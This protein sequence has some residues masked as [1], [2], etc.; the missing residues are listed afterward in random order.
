MQLMEQAR[1]EGRPELW[2]RSEALFLQAIERSPQAAELHEGLGRLYIDQALHVTAGGIAQK[3]SDKALKHF[4]E[5]VRLRPDHKTHHLSLAR[6][7]Q[8]RDE[9]A[10]ALATLD[11]ALQR[12]PGDRFV[13]GQRSLNLVKLGRLDEAQELALQLER[14]ARA[15][16][17]AHNLVDALRT[18]QDVATARGDKEE[19]A[20]IALELEKIQPEVLNSGDPAS[21]S[22]V[23]MALGAMY[24]KLG[25]P[26]KSQ[27]NFIQ[28]AETE[29][30]NPQL[31]HDV[32]RASLELG[33]LRVARVF[34]DRA[35]T[36]TQDPVFDKTRARIDAALASQ[37]PSACSAPY[38]DEPARSADEQ[39]LMAM[40]CFDSHRFETARARLAHLADG[41]LQGRHH[42][43]EGYIR[44]L[45]KDYEGAQA[46]F[47]HPLARQQEAT[48]AEIGLA[49]LL[50]VR[51][52]PGQA[53]QRLEDAARSLDQPQG[54]LDDIS[55]PGQY[56]AWLSYQMAQLGLGW[57]HS[58]QNRHEPALH[59]Y[60]R[61]LAPE[62][63]DIF[64][65]LG[66]ANS[67]TALG[68]LDQAQA[69]LERVLELA[70]SN[71]YALAELALVQLNKGDHALAEQYF[72]QAMEQDA[73]QY[74]CPHEGLGLVYLKR[75][76][77]DAARQ[78]FE[79]AIEI[80]PDIEYVKF[81]RLA[82]IYIEE[83]RYD[84][85]RQLL[86]KSI[87]N[88]PYDDEAQKMLEALPGG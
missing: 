20:K 19:I 69:L 47:D 11:K 22:C 41:A 72:Q 83:G 79:K 58:N 78:S 5:A 42:V 23:F 31:Q 45:E 10:L 67:A 32:A 13:Q 74:T 56:F 59:C 34:I 3:P 65:L 38:T 51:K 39:T 1:R 84:E 55:D 70:P 6:Y 77:R 21:I 4:E 27:L 60:E 25:S 2:Q 26:E 18:R 54:S 50:L 12:W 28:A 53:Q 8:L 80:N 66:K 14:E 57:A 37:E 44:L 85:A 68:R 75:G 29:P 71:Q 40:R 33:D 36:L 30:H 62:P 87:E 64:A 52:E 16:G 35:L 73:E 82:E 63:D 86:R 24:G 48:A 17:D 43:L 88:Y 7:H 15:T 49:H 9:Y 46:S 81:N 76:K 61:V